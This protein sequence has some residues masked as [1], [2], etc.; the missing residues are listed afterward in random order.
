MDDL[1]VLV[2]VV[3]RGSFAAAARELGTPTSTVS[4]AIARLEE[5]SGVRL[6][7]RTTRHLRP[8]TDGRELYASVVPAISSLRATAQALEP[9]GKQPRGR[10]RVSAA[11][12]LFSGFLSDVVV[13]FA[14]RYPHVQLDFSV[15]NQRVNLVEDG[16]DVALRASASLADSSLVARKLGVVQHGLYASP[17]YL[18]RHG[19]PRSPQELVTHHSVVF[20]GQDLARTWQLESAA[21]PSRVAVRGRLGGDDLGFVRAMLVAGGGIGLLP[22]FN[23]AADEASGRLVRVLPSYRARGATLYLVYPSKRQV[24]GRLS[25]FRDFVVEAFAAWSS[26]EASA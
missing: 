16:I 15:T 13:G 18:E 3:E 26:G 22:R 20:R 11:S 2:R 7:Q 5:R 4:R 17:K 19:T 21:G 1:A 10:L 6:L 8:T 12:D 24:P 14:E 25:A 9:H 23:C